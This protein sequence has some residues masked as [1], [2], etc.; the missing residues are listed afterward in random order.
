MSAGPSDL[1]R[2][3]APAFGAPVTGLASALAVVGANPNATAC[4]ALMGCGDPI[5][6]V[7][8][9]LDRFAGASDAALDREMQ[10]LATVADLPA[11]RERGAVSLGS[12]HARARGV[13]RGERRRA[14]DAA[15]GR[16]RS[17]TDSPVARCGRA[18][19]RS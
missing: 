18:S 14:R 15:R 3:L 4:A 17:A 12:A 11:A 13:D 19:P 10:S 7:A 1:A 9:Q 2:A 5:V 8:R 6:D 16:Q